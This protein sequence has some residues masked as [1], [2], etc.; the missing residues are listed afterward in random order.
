M[1]GKLG[2][3]T[4]GIQTWSKLIKRN[5]TDLK[6]VARIRKYFKILTITSSDII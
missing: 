3:A 2:I 6:I 1:Y 4:F 5:S